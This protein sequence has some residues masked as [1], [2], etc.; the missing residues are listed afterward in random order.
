MQ[1]SRRKTIL[2][3]PRFQIRVVF[4]SLVVTGVVSI[5]VYWGSN[6]FFDKVYSMLSFHMFES[7]EKTIALLQEQRDLFEKYFLIFNCFLFSFLVLTGLFISHRIAGP[8][9]RVLQYAK[10][11]MRNPQM[12]Q[13]LN[14]RKWDMFQ[15]VVEEFNSID[16]NNKNKS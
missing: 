5:V 10:E 9:Y 12:T 4:Y 13:E 11:R 1:Q 6:L 15:E 8:V 16:K 14:L 7:S 2:V 3:N